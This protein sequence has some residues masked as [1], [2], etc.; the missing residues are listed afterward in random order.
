MKSSCII[1][2]KFKSTVCPICLCRA[3]NR[4][5][6]L[7][8]SLQK[9]YGKISL[10]EFKSKLSLAEIPIDVGISLKEEYQIH[11]SDAGIFM[12]N[13]YTY[14]RFCGFNFRFEHKQEIDTPSSEG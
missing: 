5:R 2:S 12:V 10:E 1:P 9:E 6:K 13:Y 3:R 7:L 14:C 8:E 11:T 4:K